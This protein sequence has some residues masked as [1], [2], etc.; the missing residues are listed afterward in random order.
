MVKNIKYLYCIAYVMGIYLLCIRIHTVSSLFGSLSC[1]CSYGSGLG[2]TLV[3]GLSLLQIG[4]I[5][6]ILGY[7]RGTLGCPVEVLEELA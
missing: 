5:L 4:C 6:V 1:T 7:G 3:V 2:W